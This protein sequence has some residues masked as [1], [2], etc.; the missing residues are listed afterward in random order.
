VG[1]YDAEEEG[2][3][4]GL[5][6]GLRVQGVESMGAVNKGRNYGGAAELFDELQAVSS[7]QRLAEDGGG[8]GEGVDLLEG[9]VVD[10]A[11]GVFWDFQLAFLDVLA[12]FP[13]EAG[14]V[15][16]VVFG[17]EAGRRGSLSHDSTRAKLKDVH[18]RDET[19]MVVAGG[20]NLHLGGV[21]SKP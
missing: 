17:S 2:G 3:L 15:S 16:R 21:Y 12:E 13:G 1:T 18:M 7:W 11:G 10:E 19:Y 14:R 9:L 8:R 20:D 6:R 5:Q 4:V